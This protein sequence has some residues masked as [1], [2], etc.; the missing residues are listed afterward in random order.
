MESFLKSQSYFR[1]EYILSMFDGEQESNEYYSYFFPNLRNH[2]VISSSF[3]WNMS[4]GM[5][6]THANTACHCGKQY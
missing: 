1:V 3:I 4:A 5:T 6:A 2:Q